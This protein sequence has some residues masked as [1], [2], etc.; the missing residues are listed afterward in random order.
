MPCTAVHPVL[1]A[2]RRRFAPRVPA[3]PDPPHPARHRLADPAAALLEVADAG[4]GR[5]FRRRGRGPRRPALGPAAGDQLAERGRLARAAA[6]AARPHAAAALHA[7]EPADLSAVARGGIR[8]PFRL[9]QHPQRPGRRP[10]GLQLGVPPRGLPG[11]P[12]RLPGADAGRDPSG[13]PR[14]GSRRAA[15]CCRWASSGRRCRPTPSRPGAG[16]PCAPDA[17]PAWPRDGRRPRDP[18]EPPLGV[19][20]GAGGLRPRADRPRRRAAWSSASSCSASRARTTTCRAASPTTSATA[21][22]TSAGRPTRRPTPAGWRAPTSWS[23][24]RSRSTSGSR[25]PRRCTPAP[26]RCCRGGRSIR[27]ST[28]GAAGVVTST[29]TR[30]AWSPCSPTC[31]QGRCGH[32]CSLQN[33]IDACCWPRLIGRFDDL[34]AAVAGRANVLAPERRTRYLLT[35]RRSADDAAVTRCEPGSA[36]GRQQSRGQQSRS[37]P[38]R[39]AGPARDVGVGPAPPARD[40]GADPARTTHRPARERPPAPRHRGRTRD[41]AGAPVVP[42]DRQRRPGRLPAHPRHDRLSRRPARARARSCTRAA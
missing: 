38:P 41:P 29:T 35:L 32:V 19:R 6:A 4:R 8:F 33:D 40:H 37:R 31:S 18:V 2:V 20:Q 30:P 24:A 14:P 5:P 23:A 11:G 34:F 9:H 26:T 27:R 16:G 17:G 3:G 28:A 25:S 36:R 12:A 42:Q 7:R 21:A 1:R 22:C 15:A 13:Y 39:A 10:R